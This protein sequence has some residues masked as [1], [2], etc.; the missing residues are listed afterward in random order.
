M[1]N[2]VQCVRAE[3]QLRGLRVPAA[4][5][6]AGNVCLVTEATSRHNDSSLAA[7]ARARYK[8]LQRCWVPAAVLSGSSRSGGA[9]LQ[10]RLRAGS[11]QSC[12]QMAP[13][14]FSQLCFTQIVA[15]AWCCLD[16]HSTSVLQLPGTGH[17]LMYVGAQQW[18]KCAKAAADATT[19]SVAVAA[20]AS[21]CQ[22]IKLQ[23]GSQYKLTYYYGE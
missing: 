3:L 17:C 1:G 21:Y 18:C 6:E 2:Q 19:A 23:K 8:P 16:A 11:L 14:S 22:D 15:A 20:A 7:T 13:V 5:A 12:C 4:A 9:P 10:G